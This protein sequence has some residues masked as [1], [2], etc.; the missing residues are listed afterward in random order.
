MIAS[1]KWISKLYILEIKVKP[2]RKPEW[3]LKFTVWDPVIHCN[4]SQ[5]VRILSRNKTH[6]RPW[7][8]QL[9]TLRCISLPHGQNDEL[10]DIRRH[11]NVP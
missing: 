1:L 9:V 2:T 7:R 4:R 3:S 11:K 10:E 5:M 6:T 8:R